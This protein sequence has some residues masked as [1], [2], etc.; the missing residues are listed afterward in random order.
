MRTDEVQSPAN[1]QR[2]QLGV[3]FL[4]MPVVFSLLSAPVRVTANKDLQKLRLSSY[5]FLIFSNI[6]Q[7]LCFKLFG[8]ALGTEQGACIGQKG[9]TFLIFLRLMGIFLFLFII[10][11]HYKH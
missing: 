5:S 7:M 9:T 3:W 10:C 8:H 11:S 2:G 4:G 1:L 6:L